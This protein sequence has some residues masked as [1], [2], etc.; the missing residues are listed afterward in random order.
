[1]KSYLSGLTVVVAGLSLAASVGAQQPSGARAAAGGSSSRIGRPTTTGTSTGQPI[2]RRVV[3]QAPVSSAVPGVSV[4]ATSGGVWP[5]SYY[6][7]SPYP[8]RGYVDYGPLDQFPFHGRAYGN[9]GDRWSW[10]Y[11]GGGD[12]RY[13]AKYYYPLLP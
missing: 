11:M 3:T 1:M 9:P 12:R 4:P 5:Y 7:L 8:A 6:V 10:Y 13:L 2:D